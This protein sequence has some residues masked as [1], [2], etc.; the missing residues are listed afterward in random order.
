[1]IQQAIWKSTTSEFVFKAQ[2]EK[3]LSRFPQGHRMCHGGNLH[4]FMVSCWN[5]MP[6]LEREREREGWGEESQ[7]HGPWFWLGR[8]QSWQAEGKWTGPVLVAGAHTSGM[9]GCSPTRSSRYSTRGV[10]QEGRTK[11]WFES[12][13]HGS[14][15]YTRLQFTLF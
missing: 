4:L 8:V 1:M 13:G 11:M 12:R 7:F 15:Q 5:K 2:L 10:S 9:S 3:A 14:N 6:S